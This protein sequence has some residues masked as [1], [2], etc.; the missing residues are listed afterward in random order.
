M[1]MRRNGITCPKDMSR[2]CSEF[3]KIRKPA[4][5]NLVLMPGVGIHWLVLN[6]SFQMR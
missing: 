5:G 4:P 6:F 1:S 2:S 3:K